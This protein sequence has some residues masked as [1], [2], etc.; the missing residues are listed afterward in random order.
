[1]DA[2][3]G[4]SAA[5]DAAENMRTSPTADRKYSFCTRN[6]THN[7]QSVINKVNIISALQMRA[8]HM[9]RFFSSPKVSQN[10]QELPHIL[11]GLM[12]YAGNFPVPDLVE[13]G[14]PTP[15]PHPAALGTQGDLASRRR[16]H[17]HHCI[18]IGLVLK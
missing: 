7:F 11:N 5:I 14:L 15:A 2:N 8:R 4:L 3:L 6:V 18:F 9:G 16:Q 12:I 10:V 17:H 13:D 1:M